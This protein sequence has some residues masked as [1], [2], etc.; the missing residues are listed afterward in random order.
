LPA[1][2]TYLLCFCSGVAGLV[3]E[4]A[5]ARQFGGVFGN[6][7][8]SAAVVTA[9]FMFGLGAG[10]F[11]AGRWADRRFG[12]GGPR[13]IGR[14]YGAV[15]IGAGAMGAVL[16]LVFTYLGTIS[17]SVSSYGHAPNGWYEPTLASTLARLA[18]AT[19]LLAPSSLLLGATLP[20]LVRAV[21]TERGAS[22]GWTTGVIYGVNTAGA[23]LG[24]L[25]TDL[26]LLP[27][28]GL[29][30]T[31][32]G[33]AALDL[34]VGVAAIVL[35]GRVTAPASASQVTGEVPDDAVEAPPP[36]RAERAP[37]RGHLAAAAFALF[38]SGLAALGLEIVWFRVLAAA[39]GAYRPVLSILLAT[40]LT[41]LWIGSLVG[42]RVAR[43]RI[44][45]PHVALAASQACVAA[46]TLLLLV[47]LDRAAFVAPGP[48]PAD[49]LARVASA[50][51]AIVAVVLVPSLLM[52][53]SFPLANAAARPSFTE[54]GGRAGLL[55]LAN[56][57]GSVCGSMLAGFV[58]LP[59]I[60]SQAS[61]VLFAVLAAVAP[62]PLLVISFADVDAR[63]RRVLSGLAV[64]TVPIV[65]GWLALPSGFVLHRWLAPLPRGA[66]VLAESEG[67]SEAVVVTQ[68]LDGRRV[69]F[70]NG[71]PMSG[72]GR[73]PQRYMR[74]FAHVPLL[75]QDEP[76]RALVICFGV[77]NTVHAVSLHTAIR[78]IE[79]ADLSR[80]V[81]EQAHFFAATNHDVLADPRVRV[82]V[83][84]GRQHL[85]V[86][87]PATFDLI[88][89]EP[90]PIAFAGVSAL[91]SKEF[92]ELARSRL[93]PG[94]MLTQWLPAYQVPPRTNLAMIRAFLEVFP[95]STVLLSGERAELVLL[96]ENGPAPVF[97]LD[98]VER[99]LAAE[100]AV[101]RDLRFV[102]MG[103][104]TE[105]AGAFVADAGALERATAGV[106]PVT[107]DL[108]SM[109][110]AVLSATPNEIPS[111]IFALDASRTW[112][113]KCWSADA[114]TARVA[115]L[116]R[117]LR[118]LGAFYSTRA[119]LT[120]HYP[121]E[122]DDPKGDLGPV[123][124]RSAYLQAIFDEAP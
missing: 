5:W 123:I 13:R 20:L 35:V 82:F 105:L 47:L 95:T 88:T 85:R 11:V 64:A 57:A 66:K 3:Y 26:V 72:T 119:F 17:A 100:P 70:T 83:D 107:D 27:R 10:G 93:R 96:G 97:D 90:P 112:C 73:L 80:Q 51:R 33:A 98:R 46:C 31:Q 68:E 8:Q 25:G 14:A 48:L 81:L 16:A 19:V 4:I 74:A 54:V 120:S 115:D 110:Y 2:A 50:T 118:V 52:G 37:P 71:H 69:L 61:I 6:T 32:L 108:P 103:T 102:R 113:P 76:E 9:V 7:V 28:W 114:P 60:G 106:P 77:G 59:T 58:L 92:Y 109:E 1:R 116:D 65:F 36:P 91:Y 62:L 87:K 30:R 104:L 24:A 23:A 38:A 84:D 99:R 79:V 111:S 34:A 94:G 67:V 101:A 63:A 49:G 18:V 44:A 56:T 42:A 121:V 78:S 122:I 12:L 41:G 45:P 75:M 39:F 89:L 117:Y 124:A 22:V 29:M 40:I 21:H 43:R 53:F 55:Y 86:T 15:E